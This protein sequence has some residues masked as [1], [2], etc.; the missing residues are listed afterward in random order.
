VNDI[1][2]IISTPIT[3]AYVEENY[4]YEVLGRDLDPGDVLTYS[5]TTKPDNM[6]IDPVTGNITW[7]PSL[8][9]TGLQN[10]K[11]VVTDVAGAYGEQS[12]TIMVTDRRPA[13][14]QPPN[15]LSINNQTIHVGEKLVI[16]CVAIDVDH[17]TL[18]WSLIGQPTG[19]VINSTGVIT[20]TPTATDLGTY[21]FT[22]RVTDGKTAPV[23][24]NVTVIVIPAPIPPNNKP[25]ISNIGTLSVEEGSTFTTTVAA[26]DADNDTLRYSLDSAPAGMTIDQVTG[27]VQWTTSENDIGEHT[28]V[29]RVTDG[30]DNVT[31]TFYVRVV[32][33]PP[34][35]NN[36]P[37]ALPQA[38]VT[39]EVGKPLSVAIEATD[40]DGD[41]LT[42]TLLT[43][44]LV[45]MTVDD[46]GIV[47]WTPRLTDIGTWPI[48]V[49]V[50]D[51]KGGTSLVS[52]N[53]T[54]KKAPP[55]VE[56]R[57]PTIKQVANMD[58]EVG[59]PLSV[60]VDAI[61][62]DSYDQGKLA[63]SIQWAP[64]GMV[65]GQDGT[66]T[67]TPAEVDLGAHV[68]AVTV[69]DTKGATG[70][71]SFNVTVIPATTTGGGDDGG[72][73]GQGNGS[74]LPFLLLLVVLIVVAMV[75]MMV[76]RRRQNGPDAMAPQQPQQQPL[77]LVQPMP[78]NQQQGPFAR[79]PEYPQAQNMYAADYQ[80]NQQA[81]TTTYSYVEPAPQADLAG[82]ES[83]QAPV[84]ENAPAA[85]EATVAQ[86]QE[87]VE[88]GPS[89]SDAT[90]D[91]IVIPP[92]PPV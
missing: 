83:G 64:T 39:V 65:L 69:T 53:V 60:T 59:K 50:S 63:L 42:F 32:S 40:K 91:R 79:P 26:T 57:A 80:Q 13:P 87:P 19:M 68:I 9:Q 21:Q 78:P 77:P 27:Q 75:V 72:A 56:N 89:S 8:S 15:L 28:V 88:T 47:T 45:G 23:E 20:W 17:D 62:L 14:N 85:G 84:Q 33:K 12:Y 11:I 44:T 61:D 46:D 82:N 37:L 7:R 54:V 31:T 92:P 34:P 48:Q 51:G 73:S 49:R 43:T 55:I 1:P 25:V 38:D 74:V 29:V 70:T 10:V 71:M 58:L 16:P 66:I 18:T 86:T 81:D 76:M 5:L 6:T 41:T 35:P 24:R 36:P 3:N 22:V 30:K 90:G 2:G 4:T 67:W 52:F